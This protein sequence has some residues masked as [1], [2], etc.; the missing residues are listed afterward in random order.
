MRY[1]LQFSFPAIQATSQAVSYIF[2]IDLLLTLYMD[3]IKSASIAYLLIALESH[4]EILNKI[5]LD[6]FPWLD[7]TF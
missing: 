4:L 6:F 2:L 3:K 7:F 1:F 5:F